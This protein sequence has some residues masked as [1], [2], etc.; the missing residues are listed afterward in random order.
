MIL[1]P[2]GIVTRRQQSQE[3]LSRT[4]SEQQKLDTVTEELETVPKGLVGIAV[5]GNC[6]AA[7]HVSIT[8]SN[9]LGLQAS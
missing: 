5:T 8:L 2:Q 3:T 6:D 1:V 4:S 7:L 9:A